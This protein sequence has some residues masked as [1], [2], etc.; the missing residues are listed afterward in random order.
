MACVVA[1]VGAV[2]NTVDVAEEDRFVYDRDLLKAFK[3]SSNFNSSVPSF[4]ASRTLC[5][6]LSIYL[7]PR[8]VPCFWPVA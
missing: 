7:L 6:S 1:A 8:R 5:V 4:A 3:T 2:E